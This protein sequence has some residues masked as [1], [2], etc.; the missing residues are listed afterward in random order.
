MDEG[1]CA[2]RWPLLLLLGVGVLSVACSAFETAL[3]KTRLDGHDIHDIDIYIEQKINYIHSKINLKPTI[4][5]LNILNKCIYRLEKGSSDSL[6]TALS[7][8]LERRLDRIVAK[9]VRV[10]GQ[11]HINERDKRSIEFVGDLISDLFGN[12]GP[13]DWKQNS[14]NVLA[15]QKALRRVSDNVDMDHKDIDT[16][17]HAVETQN[18]EIR[19]LSVLVNQNQVELGSLSA[20]MISLKVYFEVLVLMEALEAQVESLIVMKTDSMKGFCSDQAFSKQFLVENLQALEANKIGLGPVF[21]SWEWRSYYKYVMCSV[22]LDSDVVWVTMR[23][24]LIQKAEKLIRVIPTAALRQTIHKIENY[25]LDVILFREK[26]NEKYH[27][28][29][30]SSLDFCNNLGTTRTCGVRDIRFEVNTELV[31]P[32]EFALNRVILVSTERR[33]LKLMSRCPNGMTEHVMETDTVLLIP[34]NC[35]YVSKYLSIDTRESDVLI[36]TE[37]GIVHFDKLEISSVVSSFANMSVTQIEA[38]ARRS[39]NSSYENYNRIYNSSYERNR[40][41][42]RD[43]LNDIDTKHN[44]LWAAYNIEKW[45]LIGSIVAITAILVILK[46]AL[47][48]RK[49]LSDSKPESFEMQNL[50]IDTD[51][52]QAQLQQPTLQMTTQQQQQPTLQQTELIQTTSQQHQQ[53]QQQQQQQGTYQATTNAVAEHVYTE[54]KPVDGIINFSSP[55]ERSQFYNKS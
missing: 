27:I 25:G 36:T 24:P 22:A 51:L 46:V 8:T 4:D 35:S 28:I 21:G 52:A 20:E 54:V 48:M 23:I 53:Q 1:K 14:A 17:R 19:S 32:V 2:C 42:A 38:I 15:L 33:A 44:K 5:G 29:S 16:N 45:S 6:A 49:K 13:S 7:K 41:L 10:S 39:A 34:N 11:N 31:L 30:R 47:R 26:D 12:P 3:E 50:K 40:I 37:I 55:R 9:L 18:I 43:E